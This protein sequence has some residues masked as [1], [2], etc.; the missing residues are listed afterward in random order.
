VISQTG[1]AIRTL[2][3]S[4]PALSAAAR[5]QP[6]NQHLQ[7]HQRLVTSNNLANFSYSQVFD[8]DVLHLGLSNSSLNTTSLNT[9]LNPS[10]ASSL[11]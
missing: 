8:W 6:A 7:R 2:T 3:P 4:S 10:I 9:N 5:Q 11:P 1:T